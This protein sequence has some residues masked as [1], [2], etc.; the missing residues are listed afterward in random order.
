MTRYHLSG[1]SGQ[2]VYA[3]P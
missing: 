3:G 1:W 2:L